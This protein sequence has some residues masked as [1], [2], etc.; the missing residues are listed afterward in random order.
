MT[1]IVRSEKIFTSVPVGYKSL[2]ETSSHPD[3]EHTSTSDL[4]PF[5]T[6]PQIPSSGP[7]EL[8]SPENLQLSRMDEAKGD[9]SKA[10][11]GILPPVTDGSAAQGETKA[12]DTGDG[13]GKKTTCRKH[14]KSPKKTKKRSKAKADVS[15]SSDDSSSTD[16]T[17]SSSESEESTESESSEEEDAE[18][19]KRRKQKAKRAKKLKEK[20]KAKSRK[21]KDSSEEEEETDSSDDSSSDE[22]EKRKKAKSKKKRRPKK[23]RKDTE[24]SESEEEGNESLAAIAKAQL[25]LN[26]RRS[27]GRRARGGRHSIDDRSLKKSLNSKAK[28][29]KKKR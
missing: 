14:H 15:S 16:D 24:S 12:Q 1:A 26:R 20:R 23:N 4:T 27:L 5:E 2:S 11:E 28:A 19:V 9:G 17:S 22:D 6:P 29:K 7:S 3:P 13:K 18:A 21:H 10:K 8:E 25:A